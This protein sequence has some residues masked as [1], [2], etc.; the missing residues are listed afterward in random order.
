MALRHRAAIV[1]FVNIGSADS[2]PVFAQ[3]RSRF[4][5][6]YATWPCIPISTF[7]FLPVPLPSKWHVQ[8]LPPIHAEQQYPPES[9][10]DAALVK[11]IGLDVKCRM[12]EAMETMV[13]RRRSIFF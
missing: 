9:A 2:L 1:P 8:F 13:R 3:I 4:W 7:P 11:S 10:Q 6:R 5:T 12:Q